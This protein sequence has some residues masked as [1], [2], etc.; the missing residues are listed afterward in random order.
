M[1]GKAALALQGAQQVVKWA[2]DHPDEVKRAGSWLRGMLSSTPAPVLVTG[3]KSVGKSV[4]WDFLSG[5]AYTEGYSPPDTS[6]SIGQAN[7]KGRGAGG[8]KVA[9]I[10][11]PGDPDSH[12]RQDAFERHFT[13]RKSE[14]SG[15]IYVVCA[16]LAHPRSPDAQAHLLRTHPSIESFVEKKLEEELE[17]FD[18]TCHELES[19]WRK[20]RR[21]FWLLVV[22][23]KAD[24]Y[25]DRLAGV[26]DCY[27]PGGGGAFAR[28][29]ERLQSNIGRLNVAV[30][31]A[32]V[33]CLPEDFAWGDSIVKSE[34][35]E[36]ARRAYVVRLRA[37]IFD[38]CRA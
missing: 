21:P 4:L 12:A 36:A 34:I 5:A 30:D 3:I 26:S 11:I 8:K 14:I 13:S 7:L 38:L 10:V 33:S 18:K 16:G 9:G 28:R 25:Q 27:C 15:L 32:A 35:D 31:S 20:H 17:D 2:Q 29:V 6:A 1:S 23:A 24:L 37:K 19:Y 22:T